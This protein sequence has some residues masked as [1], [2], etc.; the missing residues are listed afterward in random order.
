MIDI[1]KYK[2]KELLVRK[3]IASFIE[4]IIRYFVHCF[5]PP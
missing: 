4:K 2:S 5:T 1:A 3:K